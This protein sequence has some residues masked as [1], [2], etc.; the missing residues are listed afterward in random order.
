MICLNSKVYHCWSDEI[1]ENGEIIVKTS[2]KGVQKKRNV[3]VKKD[4]LEMLTNPHQNHTIENSGFIREGTNIL[5][6]T[7]MKKGLNYFYAKRIVLA[8]GVTTMPLNI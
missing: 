3:L 1:D 4:F 2:C 5:T 7:Q 6:Y 8:D